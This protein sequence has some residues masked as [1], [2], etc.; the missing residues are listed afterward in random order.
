[1]AK[2]AEYKMMARAHEEYSNGSIQQSLFMLALTSSRLS[3]CVFSWESGSVL[4]STY[5]RISIAQ[6]V[7]LQYNMV[8]YIMCCLDTVG[9]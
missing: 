5:S 7:R 8:E 3:G 4:N 2:D 9:Y 1:M 6:A